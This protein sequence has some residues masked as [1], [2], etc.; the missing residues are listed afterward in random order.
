[1]KGLFH[2]RLLG[3]HLL[4][5][6]AGCLQPEISGP[7]VGFFFWFIFYFSRSCVGG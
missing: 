1:M 7:F 6:R 2:W 4:R 3:A 5:R